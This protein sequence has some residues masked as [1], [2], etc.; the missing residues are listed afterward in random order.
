MSY[1]NFFKPQ[2]VLE[3]KSDQDLI[4]LFVEKNDNDALAV[5]Y[6]RYVHL[7]YGICLKYLRNKDDS[8]DAV[9]Q[10]YELLNKELPRFEVRNFGSWLN[11]ISRNYCLMSLRRFKSKTEFQEEFSSAND[12]EIQVIP[13]HIDEWSVEDD[14]QKLEKCIERLS[15]EQKKC[16]Q[17]F[18][19]QEKSYK[20]IVRIEDL[21]LKKV[22][23]HIQNG[24]RNLKNCM[25]N[26]IE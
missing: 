18:Y 7:V 13:H 26:K 20:E 11:V 12:M 17:L 4:H 8:Q 1:F 9:M 5:L 24:K 14:L 21:E 22:K 10:I 16:V 3:D 2:E 15:E 25:E 6:Q 19:L 23:S